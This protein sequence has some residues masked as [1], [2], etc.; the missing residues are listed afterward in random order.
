MKKS[1]LLVVFTILIATAGL[2]GYMLLNWYI[3]Q[4][5]FYPMPGADLPISGLPAGVEETTIESADGLD[6]HAYYLPVSDSNRALLYL[7][8]NAG[9]ASHRIPIGMRM[10]AMG[11]N[12]LIL[13]Y[14]GYGLSEG[15]PDEQGVYLDA[16]AALAHLRQL[17]FED[18]N[19]YVFGR[20]LGGAIA[21]ELVRGARLGGLVLC[22]TFSSGADMARAIGMGWM[23]PLVGRRFAAID[24][25][26]ELSSPLLAM[27][28]TLDRIVPHALGR[29]LY[30]AAPGPRQWVDIPG[31][32]HNDVTI[33]GEDVFW[34]ALADFLNPQEDPVNLPR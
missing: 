25:I 27:H 18:H 1:R 9:N 10:A 33:A 32:G 23:A 28:G 15:R 5:T 7:H 14:R 24:R 11:I 13:D 16:R 31:A 19:I 20:S 34:P 26:D 17:G 6:L 3:N 29:R 2:A 22:S 8:G 21:V 30:E 12:V 4:M